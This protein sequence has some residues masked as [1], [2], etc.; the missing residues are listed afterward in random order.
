M[1]VSMCSVC[2]SQESK[3]VLLTHRLFLCAQ[4]ILDFSQDLD[5]GLLDRVVAAMFTGAGNDVR[6]RA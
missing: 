6:R 4:A 1:D 3:F 2:V 5:L